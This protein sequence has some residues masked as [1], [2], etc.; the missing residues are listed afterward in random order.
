MVLTIL[1]NEIILNQLRLLPSQYSSSTGCARPIDFHENGPAKSEILRRPMN[2]DELSG[3]YSICWECPH[4]RGVAADGVLADAAVVGVTIG[5][6]VTAANTGDAEEVCSCTQGG[7]DA[8]I[9]EEIG[10]V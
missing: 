10:I 1:V 7:A 3:R 8:G 9:G 4:L 6:N 2:G 5:E